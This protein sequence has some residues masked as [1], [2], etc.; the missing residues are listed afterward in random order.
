MGAR[1]GTNR[2]VQQSEAQRASEGRP[3]PAP[4]PTAPS[5]VSSDAGERIAQLKQLADLHDSGAL[6]DQEFA[7]EKSKILG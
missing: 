6:T 2:A 1:A 3:P 7:A 4:S 5:T